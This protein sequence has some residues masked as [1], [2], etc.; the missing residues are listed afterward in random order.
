MRMKLK[1]V[2]T[3]ATYDTTLRPDENLKKH[4]LIQNQFNTYTQWMIQHT[5]W[6]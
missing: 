3:G 1:D 2:R 6:I 5:L 4:T